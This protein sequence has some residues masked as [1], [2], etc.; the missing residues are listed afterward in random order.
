VPV[1]KE[2][3]V[4]H[5]KFA[6]DHGCRSYRAFFNSLDAGYTIY[7][8]VLK[9]CIVNRVSVPSLLLKRFNL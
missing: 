8:V 9:S 3:V 5:P 2:P 1:R 6:D 7:L 4:A